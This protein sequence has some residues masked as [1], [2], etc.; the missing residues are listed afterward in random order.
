MMKLYSMG[1]HETLSRLSLPVYNVGMGGGTVDTHRKTD[2]LSFYFF[3]T[4][5]WTYLTNQSLPLFRFDIFTVRIH[6]S[7]Y[8]WPICC[9]VVT[10]VTPAN[11]SDAIEYLHSGMLYRPLELCP[12]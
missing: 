2:L 9:S 12:S 3:Y 6:K 1:G 4:F 11:S 5:L 7:G 8:L 10:T